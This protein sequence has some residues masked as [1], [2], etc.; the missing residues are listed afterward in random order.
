MYQDLKS[1]VALTLQPE[2]CCL[3]T[4]LQ[5]QIQLMKET[6]IQIQLTAFVLCDRSKVSPW[7]SW[8]PVP[9]G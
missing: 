3:V 4:G 7:V 2:Q 1:H 8:M 6:S 9:D 5:S